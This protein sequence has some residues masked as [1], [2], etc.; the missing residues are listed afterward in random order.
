MIR[1]AAA[2]AHNNFHDTLV[3]HAM[4]APRWIAPAPRERHG[5]FCAQLIA[6]GKRRFLSFEVPGSRLFYSAYVPC[7]NEILFQ[8]PTHIAESV[9]DQF[10]RNSTETFVEST[11]IGGGNV[12]GFISLTDTCV[13]GLSRWTKP[14]SDDVVDE[15]PKAFGRATSQADQDWTGEW[16]TF[17]SAMRSTLITS[18]PCR[19]PRASDLRVS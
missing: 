13:K 5:V 10:G 18:R 4:I 12:P 14:D 8:F 11:F 3:N 7:F 9:T 19:D 6:A 2:A 17:R 15:I 16:R 1:Q